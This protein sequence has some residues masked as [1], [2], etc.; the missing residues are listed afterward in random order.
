MQAAI[1]TQTYSQYLTKAHRQFSYGRAKHRLLIR[2]A[3]L[4]SDYD[5]VCLQEVDLGGRRAG[6]R[7]QVEKLI[8]LSGHHHFTTQENRTIGTLSR[9]G[10]AIL[11]RHHIGSHKDI[12]LPGRFKGRGALACTIKTPFPLTVVNLHLG[13]GSQ[14]Q[15]HQLSHIASHI[16]REHPLVIAGDFNAGKNNSAVDTFAQTLRLKALSQ[17]D[18]A[19]YPAWRPVQPLDKI[20]VSKEWIDGSAKPLAATLSDHLPVAAQLHIR[21]AA[22]PI[23]SDADI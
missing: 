17:D 13:F 15:H 6:F 12:K 19:T 11:S 5:I 2:I 7:C 4:I 21:A 1:G 18:D 23:L 16:H 10:N 3:R 20:L 14:T 8:D 9:H 22:R